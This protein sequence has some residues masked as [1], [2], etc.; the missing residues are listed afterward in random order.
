M[1]RWQGLSDGS[2][3]SCSF[4][5]RETIPEIPSGVLKRLER[6]AAGLQAIA[7]SYAPASTEPAAAETP[8]IMLRRSK[9]DKTQKIWTVPKVQE[10]I[11]EALNCGDAATEE[12]YL[13][14]TANELEGMIGCD[15]KTA[16]QTTFWKQDRDEKQKA[17]RL[18]N[19]AGKRTR[20]RDI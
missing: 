19:T 17:W 14:A 10:H 20:Q 12:K 13:F 5:W 18:K 3:T 15:R 11:R 2:G 6:A 7:G 8:A 4:A 9:R 16:M 1:Y